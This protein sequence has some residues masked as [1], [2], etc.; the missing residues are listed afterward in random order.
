MWT[1]NMSD[2]PYTCYIDDGGYIYYT[3]YVFYMSNTSIHTSYIYIYRCVCVCLCVCIIFK[4]TIHLL[5]CSCFLY[6]YI[7]IYSVYIYICVCIYIY[8]YVSLCV[9]MC[10]TVPKKLQILRVPGPRLARQQTVGSSCSS[11]VGSVKAVPV[12][13]LLG[14]AR[15]SW[16]SRL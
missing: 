13:A 5:R 14:D 11:E 15:L 3:W 4:I 16:A 8:I 7:H 10:G 9:C 6:R 12:A 2:I 1:I